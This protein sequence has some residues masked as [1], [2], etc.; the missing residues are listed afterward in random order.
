LCAEP[1]DRK[2]FSGISSRHTSSGRNGKDIAIDN[3][4][5]PVA[6]RNIAWPLLVGSSG[7]MGNDPA[8]DVAL[9]IGLF[10]TRKTQL[11]V[12]HFFIDGGNDFP[13]FG[14]VGCGDV[15][16]GADLGGG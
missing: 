1:F 10:S 7:L 8:G 3:D 13:A 11:P 6:E 14:R 2:S 4:A 9:V 5:R 15:F 16:V 12:L